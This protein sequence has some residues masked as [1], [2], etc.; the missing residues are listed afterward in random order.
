MDPASPLPP[1]VGSAAPAV[2][3]MSVVGVDVA[4]CA[5][6]VGTAPLLLFVAFTDAAP[7][8]APLA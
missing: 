4:V 7:G 3:G 1:D 2:T 6:A 5:A 8:M